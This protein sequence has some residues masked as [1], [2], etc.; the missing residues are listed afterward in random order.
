M[1]NVKNKI[2]WEHNT[3]LL[4]I[5]YKKFENP[6]KRLYLCNRYPENNLFALRRLIPI[7]DLKR[8]P[9]KAVAFFLFPKVKVCCDK[10][11]SDRRKRLQQ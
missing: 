6:E 8:S 3:I 1:K 9:V 10:G 2:V 11:S 4:K 5:V 7:E